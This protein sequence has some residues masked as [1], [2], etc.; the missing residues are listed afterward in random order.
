[1]SFR[2]N[3]ESLAQQHDI[4]PQAWESD[5]GTY[6]KTTESRATAE[7]WEQLVCRLLLEKKKVLLRGTWRGRFCRRMAR[8]GGSARS[9]ALAAAP[10][11]SRRHPRQRARR[12]SYRAGRAAV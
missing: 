9:D 4:Y 6:E 2:H 7:R 5:C 11:R 3:Q 10:A 1:M 12:A 8:G